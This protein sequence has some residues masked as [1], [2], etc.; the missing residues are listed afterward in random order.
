MYKFLYII[1][2]LSLTSCIN[3]NEK[4]NVL[5]KPEL[6]NK[7]NVIVSEFES[8]IKSKD[9]SIYNPDIYEVRFIDYHD[10]CMIYI[11]SNIFYYSNLDGYLFL[12]ENLI[13]FYNLN[14]NCNK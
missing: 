6:I 14:M 13:A 8:F 9:G 3:K 4:E 11:N 12:D 10:E 1:L 7:I 2:I 5:V